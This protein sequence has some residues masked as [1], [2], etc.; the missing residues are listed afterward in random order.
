MPHPRL[1]QYP[2]DHLVATKLNDRDY[3]SLQKRVKE[4]S[5][6]QASLVRLAIRNYLR[7]SF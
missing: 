5:S 6:S 4:E 3:Q 7:S 2:L 1:E